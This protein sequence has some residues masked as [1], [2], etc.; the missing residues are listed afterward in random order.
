MFK[1]KIGAE[2]HHKGHKQN[3]VIRARMD[4]E[5]FDSR[6]NYYD[7]MV[8]SDGDECR[9]LDMVAEYWLDE[10]HRIE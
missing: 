10:G 8:R 5:D 4:Y 1:Y 7:C 3:M 9:N 6:G 2:V